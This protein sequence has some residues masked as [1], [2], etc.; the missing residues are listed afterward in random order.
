MGRKSKSIFEESQRFPP[1]I[2]IALAVPPCILLG[3][4]IWQV[5]FGH[6]WGKQPMSNGRLI[7]WTVFTT[8]IYVRLITVRLVTAVRSDSII[9][10]MRGLWRSHSIPIS[11]IR[12]IKAITYDA[13]A[14]YGGYGMRSGQNGKAYIAD[15]DEGV[16]LGLTTGGTVLVGSRRSREVADAIKGACAA[17]VKV[18][19]GA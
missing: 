19:R 16:Q 6:P 1:R 8:L 17:A 5:G 7:G 15:G 14:D 4:T 13:L 11:D 9:V 3:L 2:Y 12:S 10:S 18:R